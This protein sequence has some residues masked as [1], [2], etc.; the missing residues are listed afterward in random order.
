[1]KVLVFITLLIACVLTAR[2][3]DFVCVPDTLSPQ[4]SD[5]DYTLMRRQAWAIASLARNGMSVGGTILVGNWPSSQPVN[6]TVNVG[7]F[8]ASFAVSNFP[9]SQAVTGTF[10]QS[11]Q[12][13][14]AASLPLPSGAATSAL[15]TAGNAS[16]ASLV[17]NTA[18]LATG[19]K[20]DTMISSLAAIA[21]NSA[22]SSFS[23][24]NLSA[25][26]TVTV[27]SGAGVLHTV[28]LN[29]L[30]GV[31]SSVTLYDSTSASGT[32]IG[33]INALTVF[34]PQIYDV[35]FTN[36]LTVVVTG[37]TPPDLTI[38]YR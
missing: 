28:N 14:S 22:T 20:Q 25:T 13:V 17:T 29:T 35:A 8:P 38:S 4:K 23:Y 11:T 26:G 9:A 27:K 10:W 12:P 2:G 3:S 16:L 1:M 34:G 37:L 36:G 33:T 32:K 5:D 21:T 6:G 19:A 24:R 15:Q 30:A 7:N 18:G 31:A